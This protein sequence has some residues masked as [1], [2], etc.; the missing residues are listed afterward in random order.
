MWHEY[1]K[2]SKGKRQATWSRGLRDLLG[3]GQEHTDEEIAAEELGSDDLILLD[4]E[5]WAGV[6]AQPWPTSRL[7]D[8][9]DAEGI[10]GLRT[11]LAGCGIGW[12][13]VTR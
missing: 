6:L 9:V 7:L 12:V 11:F 10:D 8:V 13:E 4:A 1:E 3:V 2:G 5:G